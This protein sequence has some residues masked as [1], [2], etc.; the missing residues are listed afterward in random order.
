GEFVAG[1]VDNLPDL[2]GVGVGDAGEGGDEQV[3]EGGEVVGAQGGGDPCLLGDGAVRD[4]LCTV[5]GHDGEGGVDDLSSALRAASPTTVNLL[6]GI[7]GHVT[8]LQSQGSRTIV[9]LMWSGRWVWPS[10]GR[11]GSMR[12]QS[13]V[14]TVIAH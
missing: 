5:A 14:T 13:T 6:T 10:L 12:R 2:G 8:L 1:G 11:W 4:A 7:I 3:V 9:Q